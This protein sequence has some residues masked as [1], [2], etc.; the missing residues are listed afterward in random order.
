ML[1]SRPTICLNCIVKNESRIIERLLASAAP[2]IDSFCIVDTGSTDNTIE[3]VEAFFRARQ[4]PGKVIIEPFVDFGTT[5]SFAL[6]QCETITEPPP[7]FVLLLDADMIFSLELSRHDAFR[8]QLL[9]ADAHYVYQGNERFYHK[10]VRVIRNLLGCTYESPTHE[11]VKT[12]EG[13]RYRIFSRDFVFI[14]DIGDGGCKSDKFE[15]DVRLLTADLEKNPTNVR[16]WF[17]LGN[18]LADLRQYEKAIEAYRRRIELGG[19]WEEVWYSYYRIGICLKSLG[20]IDD[21]IVSWMEAYQYHPNRI[22]NLYEIATHYRQCGKNNLAYA[23]YVLAAAARKRVPLPDFLFVN[24]D[25]YDWRLDYEMTVIGYY[26]N[27]DEYPLAELCVRALNQGACGED[28]I[29]RNIWSNYK[30]YAVDLLSHGGRAVVLG[31]AGDKA[32]IGDDFV[33]STPSMV[34]M[35]GVLWVNTR[36]VNY[37]IGDAGEYIIREHITTIN[38][39]TQYSVILSQSYTLNFV[40]K[41]EAEIMKYDTTLDGLYQ[42]VEDVRLFARHTSGELLYAGNRGIEQGR[43]MVETGRI[44][45]R[46]HARSRLLCV[47]NAGAP[48]AIEKN[49]V[50]FED[51]SGLGD[52]R[53]VYGWSPL[54]IGKVV[55][56]APAPVDFFRA[57]ETVATPPIFRYFR[58]STNGCNAAAGEIWF[59]CHIVSYEGRRHYYHVIVVLKN[60]APYSV[61]RYSVPF[62]FEKSPVEY[63]LGMEYFPETEEFMFGYSVMDKKTKFMMIS[64]DNLPKW[65]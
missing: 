5:R 62:T 38:V 17:Y 9:E 42:G 65:V 33:S 27:H 14:N 23:F 51:G 61:L 4:I 41:G 3:I 15:R 49:W 46:E 8:S 52:I 35:D 56:G 34:R 11:Y 6:K 57:V 40:Q 18:S 7:D 26:C 30:F 1:L 16:S 53:Y 31:G 47:E 58:G 20:R 32:P 45:P 28:N 60:T 13:A 25:I 24:K 44:I 54:V 2:L 29:A 12:P 59:V 43:I 55:A 63:C 36:Y 19:W 21:A 50:M 39:L 22:E 64:R 37:R 10:N 48:A